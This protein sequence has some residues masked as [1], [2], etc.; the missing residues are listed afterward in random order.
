[1]ALCF[2]WAFVGV[3]NMV[4]KFVLK[5]VQQVSYRIFVIQIPSKAFVNYFSGEM[6]FNLNP[7]NTDIL[8]V[9]VISHSNPWII[10]IR[11]S[12]IFIFHF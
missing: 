10:R 1:M 8:D 12:E 3:V 2:L 11:F 6:N 9:I 4:G 7:F 5:N